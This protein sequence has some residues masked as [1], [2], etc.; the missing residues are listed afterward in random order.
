ML[1]NMIISTI[2]LWFKGVTKELTQSST[3]KSELEQYIISNNPQ[4]TYDVERLTTEFDRKTTRKVW[5]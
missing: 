3:Y 5:W 4:S 2:P 1:A